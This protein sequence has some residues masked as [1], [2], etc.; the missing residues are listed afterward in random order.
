MRYFYGNDTEL[1]LS[2][3]LFLP[4]LENIVIRK[5]VVDVSVLKLMEYNSY[6]RFELP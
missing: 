6:L 3:T 1:Y 5:Y 4:V 2:T